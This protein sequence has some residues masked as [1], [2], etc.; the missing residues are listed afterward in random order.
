MADQQAPVCVL[1]ACAAGPCSRHPPPLPLT[2]GNGVPFKLTA[3]WASGQPKRTAAS[4]RQACP[5]MKNKGDPRR[6]PSGFLGV[7]GNCFHFGPQFPHLR[8]KHPLCQEVVKA[9]PGDRWRQCGLQG[10]GCTGLAER[11]RPQCQP[12][13]CCGCLHLPEPPPKDQNTHLPAGV[14]VESHNVPRASEQ[15]QGPRSSCCHL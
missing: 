3:L 10:K 11:P 12:A 1:V 14:N 2:S 15:P 5:V 13:I 6:L 7:K 8:N 4:M 9:K